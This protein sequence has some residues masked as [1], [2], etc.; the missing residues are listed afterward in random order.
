MFYYAIKIAQILIVIWPMVVVLVIFTMYRGPGG[1]KGMVKRLLNSLLITWL[2]LLAIWI[3]ALFGDEPIPGLISE[4]I[5]SIIFFSGLVILLLA[6]LLPALRHLLANQRKLHEVQSIRHLLALSPEQF[7]EL[8]T[9]SYQ[10]LGFKARRVGQSG[11]HG[12]DVVLRTREGKK[13]VV[14]CKRYRGSVG[15][16]IVRDLYGTMISEKAERAV[17]ATTAEITRPAELWAKDKPID[18]IDGFG[19]LRLLSQARA[20][21]EQNALKRW[22]LRLAAWLQPP[23]TRLQRSTPPLCP[24]CRVPMVLHPIRAQGQNGRIRYRCANYPLCRVVLEKQEQ[25]APP[26]AH[27]VSRPRDMI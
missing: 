11:D 27:A 4:P 9:S 22:I 25:K 24:H 2:V 15:E 21:S 16:S 19:M 6:N 13:W 18:L 1:L 14:Q 7:E 17:L 26:Q 5:N 8:V 12:V 20:H 23:P 10:R 3:L